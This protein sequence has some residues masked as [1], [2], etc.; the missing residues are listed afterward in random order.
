MY[1]GRGIEEPGIEY[2][3]SFS[4]TKGIITKENESSEVPGSG[5]PSLYGKGCIL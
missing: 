2:S 3:F 5:R 4:G 1:A